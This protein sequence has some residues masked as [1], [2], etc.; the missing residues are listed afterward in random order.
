MRVTGT[1]DG[2][3]FSW[4]CDACNGPVGVPCPHCG[5]IIAARQLLPWKKETDDE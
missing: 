3:P 5:S 2:E 1:V 4:V